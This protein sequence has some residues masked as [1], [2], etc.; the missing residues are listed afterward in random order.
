M[1]LNWMVGVLL[2]GA[3]ASP[4]SAQISVYIGTPPPALVYEEPGPPPGA[5][6]VWLQGYWERTP[7]EGACW[8][9]PHYDDYREGWQL[10][11]GHWDHEDH[12]SGHWRDHDHGRGHSD[13]GPRPPGPRPPAPRLIAGWVARHLHAAVLTASPRLVSSRQSNGMFAVSGRLPSVG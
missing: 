3:I 6:F 12:D 8:T 1:R 9:H 4:S 5:G 13:P 11:E 10:H 2:A 7:F